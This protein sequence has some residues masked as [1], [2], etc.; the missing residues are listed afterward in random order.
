MA[1]IDD[2]RIAAPERLRDAMRSL[3]KENSSVHVGNDTFP[4]K[5]APPALAP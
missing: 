1:L 4:S 2:E 3:R 5:W